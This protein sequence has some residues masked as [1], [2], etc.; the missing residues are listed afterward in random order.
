MPIK[1]R[2]MGRTGMQVTELCLGTMTF[3]FQ[4]D[5]EASFAILDRA[6]DGTR[7]VESRSWTSR[8]AERRISSPPSRSARATSRMNSG[9][10]P[11]R[12]TDSA[13]SG[14]ASSV[15][16]RTLWATARPA[17]AARRGRPMRARHFGHAGTFCRK[18]NMNRP[19]HPKIRATLPL[20]RPAPMPGL[21]GAVP[22]E[23]NILQY[24]RPL[25][26]AHGPLG[27]VRA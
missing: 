14:S 3:G 6:F 27:Q 15:P 1:T 18:S 11:P 7:C 17:S 13:T 19:R 21:D 26:S 16:A 20:H 9:L 2:A 25:S 8:R 12:S 22:F 4:C 5:E 23:R 10:P 24:Q